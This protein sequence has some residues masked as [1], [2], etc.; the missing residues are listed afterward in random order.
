MTVLSEPWERSA[1]Q[2]SMRRRLA[3]LLGAIA[4]MLA[5]ALAVAIIALVQVRSIGERVEDTYYPAIRQGDG[6]TIALQ[7]AQA[8]VAA[9][10]AT[11]NEAALAPYLRL[12]GLEI[13]DGD[14]RAALAVDVEVDLAHQAAAEGM[15]GWVG[16][17]AEPVITAVRVV[18]EAGGAGGEV[19]SEVA[20]TVRPAQADGDVLFESAQAAVVAYV[21]LLEEERAVAL[22]HQEDWNQVLLGAVIALV[23]VCVMMGSLM[24][25]SLE[26]W[27]IRPLDNLAAA[28]KVVS[29]GELDREIDA[30]IGEGEVAVVAAHVENM[31]RELVH[32]VEELRESAKEIEHAHDLLSV[33]AR[34]L[35]RSNRDLEQFAY[36]ASHDLQEPLRKVAMFTGMLRNRYEG[37][38]DDRADL[39]IEYSVDGAK[40]MQRLIQDLLSFARV[41]RSTAARTDVRLEEVLSAGLH[42]LEERITETG[43]V[44]THDLLPVVHGDRALLGQLFV[45]LLSNAIKFRHPDRQPHV[46]IE[47][48]GMRAHWEVS[49]VDNG[50][51]IDPQYAERV[52][53]IF[54]RLHGRDEYPGTGIGL[55]LVKRI[56]EAHHGRIWIEQTEGGG[57]TIRF[58]LSRSA[59]P[60]APGRASTERAQSTTLG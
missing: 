47:A 22:T 34:E 2:V 24:W 54:Q 57:A 36:V 59:G 10:V 17:Y 44:V 8:S 4:G 43:A 27:V 60:G 48:R 3:R 29:D 1:P 35:E 38:L 31:R 51:G 49:F 11:C 58:T 19:C 26:T 40:R 56:V 37:K 32:H 12:E 55:A 50:I 39:Y 13:A 42:E 9:Y 5:L 20:A 30:T 25:L 18:E 7:D 53:I 41:G 45:N 14:T 46:H 16:G 6:A 52:F 28:V 23:L 15:R 21:D 33:Q